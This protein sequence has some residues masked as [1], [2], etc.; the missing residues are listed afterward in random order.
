MCRAVALVLVLVVALPAALFVPVATTFLVTLAA[1][2]VL[3]ALPV[4]TV[5]PVGVRR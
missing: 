1:A 2:V 5:I 3:P 4:V